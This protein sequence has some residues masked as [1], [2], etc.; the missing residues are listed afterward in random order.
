[1]VHELLLLK[2]IIQRRVDI[3]GYT[4]CFVTFDKGEME[5]NAE[6]CSVVVV[7]LE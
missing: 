7:P 1:M 4:P 2:N 5:E 6:K 3:F